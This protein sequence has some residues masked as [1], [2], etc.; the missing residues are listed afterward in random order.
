ME[1]WF[2]PFEL[3]IHDN[4]LVNDYLSEEE[5]NQLTLVE[6]EKFNKYLIKTKQ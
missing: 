5:K 4:P 3:T 6:L 2:E 1:N